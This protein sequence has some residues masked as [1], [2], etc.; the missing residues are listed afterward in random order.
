MAD[1][2][3][4]AAIGGAVAIAGAA[5][6]PAA[7]QS[8]A[9]ASRRRFTGK[10][11]VITGATSGIGRAAAEAFAREGASVA[12]CGRR[13]ALGREVESRLRELGAP[14]ALYVRT[15]VRRPEQVCAFI[16]A[17]A[18]RFGG[19]EIAVNNAGINWF[20]PLHEL[21]LEE[22]E[23]MAQTNTRGVLLAM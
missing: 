13:E 9:S 7:G 8:T 14:D 22:W 18:T 3:R 5:V 1:L 23:E 2:T 17:A 10:T 16:D 12:F 11:V 20:K 4:R 19:I 15:D 21:S 6:T